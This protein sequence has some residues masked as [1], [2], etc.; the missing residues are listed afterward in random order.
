MT[1]KIKGVEIN[2]S[3]ID[4]VVPP[5]NLVSLQMLQEKL[6]NFSGGADAKS[7]DVVLDCAHASLKRN[8]P[9]ITRDELAEIIDLGNM[10]E[11]M[12]AIMGA[13]GLQKVGEA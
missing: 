3:G 12:N 9:D 4:F 11:L 7:I 2:L 1:A 5:L 8:Y 13:S 10:L 6:L